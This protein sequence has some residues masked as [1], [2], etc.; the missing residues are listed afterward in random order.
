MSEIKKTPVDALIVG[1]GYAGVVMA[2]RLSSQLGWKCVIVEQR[3]HIAGNAYDYIDDAG[4][5]IHKYGPHYFRSNSQRI[6]DYLSDFTEWSPVDYQIKSY[7]RGKYWNFPINL[8]TFEQIV[9]REATSDEF[10]AWLEEQRED[11][12]EPR[13]SEE[14]ITSQVGKELYE[15][16][17]KGYTIKQ[18]KKDPRELDKSVC[19]RIP[20]RLNRDDNYLREKFQ[21]LPSKG[22]TA[23]FKN[24]L[25]SVPDVEVLLGKSYKDTVEEYTFKKLIYTGPV[26]AYFKQCFGPLPYRSLRFEQESYSGEALKERE[27]I[28]G[29]KGFWQPAMQVNYPDEKVPFTRIVEVKHATGQDVEATTIVKEYPEDFEVTGEPYYPVPMKESQE[30]YKKYK[31]LADQEENVSFI[32]RLG[33][34]K[35]YNMDQVVG[36]TLTEFEKIQN[37]YNR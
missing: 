25:D 22:Y 14:V 3:D 1:A 13:N 28:S 2:E 17:F 29:K 24:M 21:A 19:G 30:I 32:G 23:M 6:V 37:E 10:E 15:M 34:Y 20:I 7:T 4:V 35:Y 36:M 11:I 18:W 27:K 16:F 31:E 26:D 8:N 33:T 12:P 9:E 5:L